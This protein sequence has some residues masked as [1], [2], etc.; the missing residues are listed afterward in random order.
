MTSGVISA[1]VLHGG[2]EG[3]E[4]RAA[5]VEAA[6]AALAERAD[7]SLRANACRIS[8]DRLQDRLQAAGHEARRGTLH[9]DVLLVSS[10]TPARAA[11]PVI[12]PAWSG[13]R[14]SWWPGT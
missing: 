11:R 2:D 12:W 7:L 1:N 10:A 3:L 13:R 9:P 5:E 6:A 4:D 14:G 8:V